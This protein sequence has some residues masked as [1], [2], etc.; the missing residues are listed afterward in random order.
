MTFRILVL[1]SLSAGVAFASSSTPTAQTP[2]P[3]EKNA[4]LEQLDDTF[5]VEGR[6]RI[7]RRLKIEAYRAITIKGEGEDA[8]LEISGKVNMRAATGGHIVFQNVWVEITPE[9]KEITLG[10]C[11]FKGKGGIRPSPDG[12]SKAK[13]TF[14]GVESERSASVT[15]EAS[16]GTL[17]M[18]R[19]WLDGP[20]V[21][22]GMPRS[23][24]SKSALTVSLYGCSGE[25]PQGRIR[26]LLGGATIEGI[27]DGT[28]RACDFA[29]RKVH[30]ID[31]QKLFF[32]GNNARADLVEFRYSPGTKIS[33]LKIAKTDF[34][35]EKLVLAAPV[36]KKAARLTFDKCYFRG[37]EDLETIR[38]EML[39][40]AEN[41]ESGIE[42]VL[43]DVV[44]R[45]HGFGGNAN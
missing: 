35:T 36:A 42:A 17:L 27:K 33:G 22:R 16:H 31:N 3:T 5:T 29:G 25:Q 11:L 44:T 20:L 37:L 24:T 2:F 23:E 14:E 45:P 40:D 39:E 18:D 19:C 26:G 34:R 9:C 43:R 13:I 21:I 30:F 12:P 6:V 10:Q 7:P 41:S 8:T 15:L 28:I 1:L 32:D 38:G 4:R